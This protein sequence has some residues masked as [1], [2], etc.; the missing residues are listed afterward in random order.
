V[1]AACRTLCDSGASQR[2][3]GRHGTRHSTRRPALRGGGEG[4]ERRG[5]PGCLSPPPFFCPKS[6][7][8]R[9]RRL[10]HQTH[11]P[12]KTQKTEH[13]ATAGPLFAQ[14]SAP[15]GRERRGG[16]SRGVTVCWNHAPPPP[17]SL[18]SCCSVFARHKTSNCVCTRPLS[19]VPKAPRAVLRGG[20]ARRS[21]GGAELCRKS[22]T[23]PYKPF[24]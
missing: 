1:A 23:S 5:W 19:A 17:L 15:C 13:A 24:F 10:D 11:R 2:K 9:Q 21:C 14:I 12:R 8:H 18:A 7:D 16:L 20:L 4:G 22:P 6:S 3:K